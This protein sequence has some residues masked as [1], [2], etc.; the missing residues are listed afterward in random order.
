MEDYNDRTGFDN[1]WRD[2]FEEAEITPSENLRMKLDS[3]LANEETVRF[4]RRIFFYKILTAASVAFA[5]S[6]GG[7]GLYYF[8]QNERNTLYNGSS[9]AHVAENN[10]AE[11]Q[12]YTSQKNEVLD[13]SG[14]KTLQTNLEKR[15]DGKANDL[16]HH[17]YLQDD[18]HDVVVASATT[19]SGKSGSDHRVGQPTPAKT[20]AHTDSFENKSSLSK[21]RGENANAYLA[22]RRN[23]TDLKK[24]TTSAEADI[25]NEN[26]SEV[27][28]HTSSLNRSSTNISEQRHHEEGF[29]PVI[30]QENAL[31]KDNNLQNGKKHRLA[32][33]NTLGDGKNKQVDG[34]GNN[35]KNRLMDRSPQS[36]AFLTVDKKESVLSDQYVQNYDQRI[37]YIEIKKPFAELLAWEEKNEQRI[38]AAQMQEAENKKKEEKS[39]EE[40]WAGVNFSAGS[41]NHN[42]QDGVSLDNNLLTSNTSTFDRSASSQS[43]ESIDEAS[44]ASGISYSYGVNVGKRISDKLVLETGLAYAFNLSETV[45]SISYQS[46]A[47]DEEGPFQPGVVDEI[48]ANDQGAVFSIPTDYNFQN[49]FEFLS[50]PVEL[51]YIIYENDKMGFLV[52]GGVATDLFIRNE[53]T[54]ETGSFEEVTIEPGDDSPYRSMYFNGLIGGEFFYKLNNNYNISVEPTYRRALNDFTK[55]DSEFRSTPSS[56]GVGFRV[57]YIF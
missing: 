32:Q 30:K 50:I 35:K 1:E 20:P 36:Y 41:F 42:V 15:E 14:E 4:R 31:L 26:N 45:S 39:F 55:S 6:V 24:A 48:E 13:K 40:F 57:R 19:D 10:V 21:A 34:I 16:A 46:I 53:I 3:V 54:E 37:A 23:D 5:I 47:L 27:H 8:H 25:Y 29:S 9:L 7:T 33:Q 2:V 11:D 22:V 43:A 51:G 44:E 52:S 49:T 17:D 28:D 56:F 18:P 38:L 12:Q